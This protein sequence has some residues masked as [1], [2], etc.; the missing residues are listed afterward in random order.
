MVW[1]N[2]VWHDVWCGV[3]WCGVVWSG[4][5]WS[6]L[7]KKDLALLIRLFHLQENTPQTG[8]ILIRWMRVFWTQNMLRF[9]RVLSKSMC[10]HNIR[11][12]GM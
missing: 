3:V 11:N 8:H 1:C 10:Q 6:D 9:F 7:L 12:H 4:L 5:V 2:M